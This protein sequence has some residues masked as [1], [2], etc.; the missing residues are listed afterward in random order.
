MSWKFNPPPG[1]PEQPEG[2]QP[3]PGWAPDPGWPPAPQDWQF[4]VPATP[5]PAPASPGPTVHDAPTSLANPTVPVPASPAGSYDPAPPYSPGAPQSPPQSP[6]SSLATPSPAGSYPPPGPFPPASGPSYQPAAAFPPPGGPPRP[7]PPV[8]PSGGTPWYQ[9]WWAIGGTALL[10]LLVGCVGGG[11]VAVLT[12]SGDDPPDPPQ[13]TGPPPGTTGPQPSG[14]PNPDPGTG[15]TLGPGEEQSGQGPTIIPIDLSGGSDYTVS[16]EYDGDDYFST[17]LVD[18]AGE[19]V[20]YLGSTEFGQTGYSGV[21][22]LTTGMTGYNEPAAIDIT[23]GETGTWTVRINDLSE[24]PAW[25]EVTEGTGDSVLRIEPGAVT[26]PVAL[27]GT[28][29]GESNFIVWAYS[30]EDDY[31]DLLLF[32]LIGAVDERAEV[33][34]TSSQIVLHVQA[35]GA[36]TLTPP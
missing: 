7:A 34:L 33:E 30:G 22:P 35:D 18:E 5:T 14:T 19:V 8:A 10:V 11:T 20:V 32:N 16:L 24:A 31:N 3:P 28:H 27:D 29:D 2:W 6:Q 9:Q 4:W 21:W 13:T 23:N 17:T 36:W 25:P 26:D 15:D 12:D 1:W